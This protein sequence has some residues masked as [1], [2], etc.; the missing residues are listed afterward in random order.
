MEFLL[1]VNLNIEYFMV[2]IKAETVNN[3]GNKKKHKHHS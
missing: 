2:K 3:E 1:N